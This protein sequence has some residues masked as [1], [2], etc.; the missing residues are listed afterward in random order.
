MSVTITTVAKNLVNLVYPLRCAACSKSLDPLN[1]LG[2][3]KT[4]A[5]GIK[6]NPKSHCATYGDF[7]E[8]AYSAFLYEKA[9]KELIHVLKYKNRISLSGLLSE[10]MISFVKENE[11]IL[12]D[13]DVITFVP[14]D[15]RRLRRRS[16]N[17]SRIFAS[18]LSRRFGVPLADMLEKSRRTRPQNELSR[19]DRLVNLAG[20]FRI[21]KGVTITEGLKILLVD[22]VMTTGSTLEE[23]S[24]TLLS[25][26][27]AG[28][29][30]LALARGV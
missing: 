18:H 1:E 10:K 16:F 14:I 2:V 22:D 3:C 9:L 23:C 7:F 21:K 11:S 4:C 24:K 15:M 20:A 8:I 17:Q 5:D 27:A 12:T 29:K 25:A 6:P 13:I 30:C 19:E 28:V 26:G